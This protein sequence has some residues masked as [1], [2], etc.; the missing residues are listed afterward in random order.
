MPTQSLDRG[1]AVVKTVALQGYRRTFRKNH[2]ISIQ[3]RRLI[4]RPRE[5]DH[6]SYRVGQIIDALGNSYLVRFDKA[7][8]SDDAPSQPMELHTLDE[9]SRTCAN[10]GQK[11]A[12][13]FKTRAEMERW[14]AWLNEP[15]KPEGDGQ[16][17]HLRKP[18]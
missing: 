18:H 16:V 17:V 6:G 14:I 11:L 4:S 2:E 15:E 7:D 3:P 10:C 12:N 8:A 1:R 13:L 5:P 9:L